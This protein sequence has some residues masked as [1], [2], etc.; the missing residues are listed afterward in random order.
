M[1][2]WSVIL[3]TKMWLLPGPRA[4]SIDFRDASASGKYRQCNLFL[5]EACCSPTPA[6]AR[7]YYYH[8]GLEQGSQYRVP[9]FPVAQKDGVYRA[10]QSEV[11]YPAAKP[12]PQS[13]RTRCVDCA[14]MA[15]GP[16]KLKL[17]WPAVTNNGGS[18]ITGYRIEVAISDNDVI[19][20]WHRPRNCRLADNDATDAPL[21]RQRSGQVR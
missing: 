5:L 13:R 6:T 4:T 8:R 10:S 14:V 20:D 3:S 11:I 2:D 19:F 17:T 9:D 7:T 16:D 18:P 1:T 21:P 12:S 15:D